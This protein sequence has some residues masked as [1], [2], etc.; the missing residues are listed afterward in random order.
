MNIE[1]TEDFKQRIETIEKGYEYMLAYAAQ[2]RDSD[3]GNGAAGSEIRG[4]LQE[5]NKALNGLGEVALSV[6]TQ[7]SGE[8]AEAS[9]AFLDALTADGEK[10]RGAIQLVL[11]QPGISSQL[12]DNLNASIHVRALLTDLFVIDEALR[13]LV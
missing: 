6:V 2:G 8:L 10:T 13:K 3:E 7:H 5:M 1:T 11:I 9:Q 12:I 4:Y